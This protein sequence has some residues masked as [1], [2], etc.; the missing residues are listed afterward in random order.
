MNLHSGP[1]YR[2]N[3]ARTSSRT[4]LSKKHAQNDR[5]STKRVAGTVWYF[6]P[7]NRSWRRRP[8]RKALD[9][10]AWSVRRRFGCLFEHEPALDG[11]HGDGTMPCQELKGS[12]PLRLPLAGQTTFVAGKR[13]CPYTDIASSSNHADSAYH[14]CCRLRRRRGERWRWGFRPDKAE[15]PSSCF[16]W[17]RGKA[18]DGQTFPTSRP[19]CKRPD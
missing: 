5:I 18:T 13:R 1:L 14:G 10:G 3:W 6:G 2:R 12:H 8:Q 11:S 15:Q 7:G 17:S 19:S 4:R 9:Q 16:P